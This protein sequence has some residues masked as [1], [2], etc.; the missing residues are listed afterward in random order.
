[1]G[2]NRQVATAMAT[3]LLVGGVHLLVGLVLLLRD[4]H[5]PSVKRRLLNTGL[6]QAHWKRFGLGLTTVGIFAEYA[7]LGIWIVFGELLWIVALIG[8]VALPVGVFLF[9]SDQPMQRENSR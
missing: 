2:S 4:P 7:A 8:I 5:P 6:R 3:I 9:I 1:M